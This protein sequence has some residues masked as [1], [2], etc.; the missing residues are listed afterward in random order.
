MTTT[1]ELAP[2]PHESQG[3][4]PD[5]LRPEIIRELS[6]LRPSKAIAAIAVEWLG[7]A[8]AIALCE[9]AWNPFLYGLAVLWIGARQHALTVLGHDAAH[10]RL[11]PDRR[12]NDWLGNL[13][14]FWPTFVAVE[15]Y[16]QFHAEHHRFTGL[17][18]DGNRR[19]WRTHTAAGNLTAE[20]SFPKTRA[21]L[22]VMLLRRAAFFT[23][24]FWIVRGLAAAVVLRRSWG[25]VVLRLLFYAVIVG[26]LAMTGMLRAFLL[27][28]IVPFCTAHIGCQYIRLICEH[29]AV[30]SADPAYALTRTTLA[31]WWERWLIVPR[32]IHYHIEHHWYPSVPFY[33][34]PALH[35]RL[36]AQPRFRSSAVVTGSVAA[37]LRQCIA[38]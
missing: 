21:A 30:S 22:A 11:L 38:A 20:W 33:N 7:I 1:R 23:G 10:F 37:S 8:V 15:N 18:Q 12:W 36:M 2:H 28:W 17:P 9:A 19:I 31:R 35:E 32:N 14:A 4:V 6:V 27:Y 34:L 16:R 13:T 26:A 24:F 29:S 3:A 25:Q 5:R